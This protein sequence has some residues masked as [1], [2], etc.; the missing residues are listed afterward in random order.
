MRHSRNQNRD[1][2]N[3]G[4]NENAPA[5]ASAG[6]PS[7]M[8]G[9]LIATILENLEPAGPAADQVDDYTLFRVAIADCLAELLGSRDVQ[10]IDFCNHVTRPE[11]GP[12]RS[13]VGFHFGDNDTVG[14][15]HSVL[16]GEVS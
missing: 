7:R 4:G 3:L 9:R 6:A 10:M 14:H 8:A 12:G 2:E 15:F 1:Q 11:A 16:F 5:R 13:A